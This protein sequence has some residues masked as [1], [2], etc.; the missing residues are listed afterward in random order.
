MKELCFVYNMDIT[1]DNIYEFLKILEFEIKDGTENTYKK[2]YLGY[3]VEII[4]D[5]DNFR[6]SKIDYGYF[7]V[8]PAGTD[9]LFGAFM[10][11]V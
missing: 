10:L 3:E 5:E 4:I 7:P 9:T 11:V 8:T 6:N 1:Q 2:E